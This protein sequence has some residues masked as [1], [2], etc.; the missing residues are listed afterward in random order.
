MDLEFIRQALCDACM[1]MDGWH[2]DVAWTE[3]DTDVLK[4]CRE[5]L[6]QVVAAQAQ[7]AT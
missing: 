5:A 6:A 3:Y 1:L 2:T 4:R 7:T